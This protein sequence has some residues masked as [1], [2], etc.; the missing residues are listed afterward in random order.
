MEYVFACDWIWGCGISQSRT[1]IF[2]LVF[3]GFKC[4]FSGFYRE[5]RCICNRTSARTSYFGCCWYGRP[6]RTRD[7]ME[8]RGTSLDVV[9]PE[10]SASSTILVAPQPEPAGWL[11]QH[12]DR[13]Q[14][15][16]QSA[17]PSGVYGRGK[18]MAHVL[19]SSMHGTRDGWGQ[20]ISTPQA[21]RRKFRWL[22]P[23]AS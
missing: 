14:W 4:V 18:E 17:M 2:A 10:T 19:L 7:E 8:Q 13:W 21:R 20:G 16:R 1:L 6:V 9:S 22:A 3:A 11:S 23:L 5:Q 15:W 12:H